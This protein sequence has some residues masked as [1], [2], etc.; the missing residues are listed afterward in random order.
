MPASSPLLFSP[1]SS[2]K[3]TAIGASK[4]N[5]RAAPIPEGAVRGFATVGS[6][7]RSEHFTSRLDNDL[8]EI[9]QAQSRRGSI[10]TTEE[11][12]KST[13]ATKKPPKRPATTKKAAA[14]GGEKPK[15]KPR[16]RKPKAD[17]ETSAIDDPELPRPP[18]RSPLFDLDTP[19]APKEDAPKLTKSGKPRKPRAKK[20]K[21]EDGDAEAVAKPKTT[22][23]TK[24]KVV[25]NGK[26]QREDAPVVSAHFRNDAAKYEEPITNAAGPRTSE[27]IQDAS[28]W[29]VPQSP[30]PKK[31]KA[32]PKRQSLDPVTE[33]LD[34]EEAVVRR[35]DWT[36]PPETLIPSPY[37]NS[38]GKENKVLRQN[39]DGTFSNML[40]NF[41]Y[42]QSPSAQHVTKEASATTEVMAATKRRRVE[43]FEVPNNQAN[44]RESS[45]EKGKAPKKKPRTITDLVTGQYGP[46][47]VELDPNAVTSNFFESRATVTKVPLNDTSAPDAGA[48]AAPK[49]APRK[50]NT[51]K[52]ASDKAEPKAKSKKVS[53]KSAAKSKAV[54]E[55]LLSPASALLRMN[56]QDI[57]FGTSSQLALEESPTMVRQLQQAIKESEQ[58]AD[59]HDSFSLLAPPRWPRLGKVQGKRG[60]WAASTR[61][62]EG[63]I[64]EHMKDVYIPAPDRT[65]DIPLLMDGSN[66]VSDPLRDVGDVDDVSDTPPDIVDIDDFPTAIIISSDLPTPPHITS[67]VSQPVTTEYQMEDLGVLDIDSFEQEPPPSNQNAESQN[68]CV[69]IDD[70]DFPPSVQTRT[71]PAQKFKP[72]VSMSTISNG[73]PKK[74]VGRPPKSLSAVTSSVTAC[75]TPTLKPPPPQPKSRAKKKDKTPSTPP[76]PSGRFAD[77][78]EIL[79]SED[80]ALELH[81]PTP[82]RIRNFSHLSLVSDSPSL[83]PTKSAKTLP[84]STSA[85]DPTLASIHRIPTSHLEWPTIKP[86][87]F[88]RITS[89]IRSL[90][91]STTPSQPTWHEKILMYDP[92]VLEDFT[93]YLNSHTGIRTYR[94]ATQKQVK[95]WNAGLKTRGEAAISFESEEEVLAVERE[96]EAG[97]VQSWCE[98]LS[99]CCIWKEGRKSGARKG[100][101]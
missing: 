41:T 19:E 87:I 3:E 59:S 18:T 96:L 22:R 57:L 51:S 78:E 13:K 68:V 31:K 92:I 83:S 89:H 36:P 38:T 44:S 1:L 46:R 52:S 14:E 85:Q 101:Y 93:A 37:T 88:A 50:R 34:L 62:D 91:P 63:G 53:A 2:P 73:S 74:R 35:R 8:P 12:T 29:D 39:D 58:E 43:L 6:L 75:S 72:P 60:L 42:A 33:D 11:P 86:I 28:I 95:T 7:I 61:D 66:E 21:D 80:E 26:A 79:D 99:V 5:F 94:K 55:K 90:P 100:L 67:Q 45:P 15:A 76:R 84:P 40:S 56:R 81:S 69:D 30:R 4:T 24:P 49:K 54:A 48:D 10:E 65:Q 82:P 23:V 47:D 25:K 27:E 97:M 98:S 64:L 77:I 70:F 71:S 9:Q 16:A 20:Q 17:K 32:A